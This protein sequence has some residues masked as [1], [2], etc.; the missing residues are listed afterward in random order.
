MDLP[1]VEIGLAQCEIWAKRFFFPSKKKKFQFIFL[2][3]KII[4]KIDLAHVKSQCSDL[5]LTFLACSKIYLRSVVGRNGVN[6]PF[7]AGKK[8][9]EVVILYVLFNIFDILYAKI[10]QKL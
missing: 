7:E 3:H 2:L 1:K 5:L 10:T 9:K 4:Q 8:F 6:F